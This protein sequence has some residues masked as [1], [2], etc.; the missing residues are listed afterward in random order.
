MRLT[1]NIELE[2]GTK[3][4]VTTSYADIIALEDE[5]DIDASD[6]IKRQKAKWLAF[7]A[8]HALKRKQLVD[9]TFDIFRTQVETVDPE[10]TSGN[11]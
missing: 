1:F 11:D 3:H 7:L 5:F 10:D 4:R 8:W 2:D 6:L 9:T